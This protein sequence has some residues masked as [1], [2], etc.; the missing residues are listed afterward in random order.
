MSA[1]D[2][3]HSVKPTLVAA[4]ERQTNDSTAIVCTEVNMQG[5]H[6]LMYLIAIGTFSDA[7]ATVT[8]LLEES[9]TSGSGYSAV[10]DANLIGTE[11]VASPTFSDD[12]TLFQLGYTGTKQ[13]SR[14][15]LTPSN[16]DSGS[17]DYCV[18]ALQ[19]HATGLAQAT[20]S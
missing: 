17:L 10:A 8:A 5:F 14:L 3:L 20:P 2:L 6:S 4:P 15:T 12:D 1:R 16:N 13:Y 19:G 11:A 18:I 9:D 7:D